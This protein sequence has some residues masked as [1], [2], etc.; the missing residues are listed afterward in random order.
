MS[1][2]TFSGTGD[3]SVLRWQRVA[4]RVTPAVQPAASAAVPPPAP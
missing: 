4:V 3:S 1:Q 2:V